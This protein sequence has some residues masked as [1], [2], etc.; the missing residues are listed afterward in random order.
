ME[1][2]SRFD[3]FVGRR[4]DVACCCFL[5]EIRVPAWPLVVDLFFLNFCSSLDNSDIKSVSIAF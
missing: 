5:R 1:T 4:G 3:Y 2:E